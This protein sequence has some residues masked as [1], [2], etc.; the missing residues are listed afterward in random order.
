MQ[1]RSPSR[2]QLG[3][4]HPK[5]SPTRSLILILT[6]TDILSPAAFKISQ[7]KTNK[8]KLTTFD[9]TKHSSF[10][11]YCRYAAFTVC[12]TGEAFTYIHYNSFIHSINHSSQTTDT[13]NLKYIKSTLKLIVQLINS[14]KITSQ[15][16]YPIEH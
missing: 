1:Q 7:K 11:G 12:P 15:F 8:N 5:H 9:T 2:V 16:T 4:L 6:N 3:M 10:Q 13:T 14:L